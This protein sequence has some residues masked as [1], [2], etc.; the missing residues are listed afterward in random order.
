[1]E[2]AFFS[3]DPPPQSVDEVAGDDASR[4]APLTI[5][6]V[7]LTMASLAAL[8]WLLQPLV[9]EFRYHFS[10][11]ELVDIGD[12]TNIGPDNVPPLGAYVKMTG[13][14]GNKAASLSGVLRP[15]SLRGGPVQIR[16]VLG[17]ALFVEFDQETF[18]ERYTTFTRITVE[19]RVA[20]LSPG[21]DLDRVRQYFETQLGLRLPA[22]ARVIVVGEKPGELWRYPIAFALAA[23]LA[24]ISVFFTVRS[25]FYR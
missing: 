19:G 21:G 17:S 8:A 23:V 18:L 22:Q 10:D 20:S 13:V 6:R 15:G 9:D 14:L 25:Y 3:A 2:D 5:Q 7:L 11:A 4:P 16:Q 1:M 12:A 24:L